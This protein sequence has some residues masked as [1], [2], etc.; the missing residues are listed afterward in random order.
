M[1][2]TKTIYYCILHS[3]GMKQFGRND[4]PQQMINEDFKQNLSWQNPTTRNVT[5][6]E[7][8]QQWRAA[9]QL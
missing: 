6:F 3:D 4:V 1:A 2:E 8:E 7:N 5:I 9:Q